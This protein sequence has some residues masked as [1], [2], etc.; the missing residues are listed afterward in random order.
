MTPILKHS[1]KS[2]KDW[3]PSDSATSSETSDVEFQENHQSTPKQFKSTSNSRRTLLVEEGGDR[4]RT[5]LAL[6]SSSSNRQFSS[7]S[8]V[9]DKLKSKS[10]DSVSRKLVYGDQQS[11]EIGLLLSNKAKD[12]ERDDDRDPPIKINKINKSKTK[13]LDRGKENIPPKSSSSSVSNSSDVDYF[14]ATS[15][16]NSNTSSRSSSR[17]VSPV[18]NQR[19]S[20]ARSISNTSVEEQT[21]VRRVE[22]EEM[23]SK[24]RPSRRLT[25]KK[26]NY[27][28][29]A[30]DEI[31]RR[32]SPV[33]S[34]SKSKSESKKKEV[35]Q[36]DMLDKEGEKEVKPGREDE[37]SDSMSIKKQ[38]KD[39]NKESHSRKSS[40]SSHLLDR[41]TD[42]EE[43][44]DE[45][46]A[47]PRKSTKP[48]SGGRTSSFSSHQLQNHSRISSIS[49]SRSSSSQSRPSMSIQHTKHSDPGLEEWNDDSEDELDLIGP[50]SSS[51][52]SDSWKDSTSGEK[53]KSS[54]MGLTEKVRKEKDEIQRIEKGIKSMNLTLSGKPSRTS[55]STT[56][57]LSSKPSTSTNKISK[58]LDKLLTTCHPPQETPLDFEETLNNLLQS[59]NHQG[60]VGKVIKIGE[61]SYSEVYTIEFQGDED[62]VEMTKGKKWKVGQSVLKII[63]ILNPSNSN[64]KKFEQNDDEEKPEESEMKDVIKEISIAKEL[65]LKEDEDEWTGFGGFRG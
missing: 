24:G 42:G 64:G 14:S 52:S 9:N 58:S 33:K 32:P 44:G 1:N 8:N 37:N 54:G 36:R 16:S 50:P 49:Q 43:E 38:K 2:D 21:R 28:E 19:Q 4:E 47:S 3:L 18:R 60:K 22:D 57:R 12:K 30:E 20:I 6:K 41:N 15:N 48:F 13:K 35:T 17:N 34:K 62:K 11:G 59:E 27:R 46:D 5:P 51:S 26:I 10:I 61:A 7:T 53:R 23:E 56:S 31:G 40:S 29:P 55:S 45:F 25:A 39:G 63:P 65:G